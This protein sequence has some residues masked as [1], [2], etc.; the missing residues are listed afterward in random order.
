MAERI[1][2]SYGEIDAEIAERIVRDTA[3]RDCNLH[4]VLYAPTD[5]KFWVAHADGMEDAW[6]QPSLEFSLEELLDLFELQNQAV[7][8]S[9]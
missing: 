3:M 5:L 1:R 7:S 9:S 4:W 2:E 6:K 8:P